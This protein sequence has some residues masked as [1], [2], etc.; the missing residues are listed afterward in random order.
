LKFVVEQTLAG[1]G[2]NLKES[3]IG[4]EVFGRPADYD[5]RIDPIVRVEAR[6]LRSR[7]DKY[8]NSGN[9]SDPVRI[10]LP[11]GSYVPSF[12]STRNRSRVSRAR[13]LGLLAL[14]A[15]LAIAGLLV[16]FAPKTTLVENPGPYALRSPLTNVTA[17]RRTIFL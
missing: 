10:L 5:P 3:V 7:L 14:A 9:S 13:V 12:E 4:V 17:T 1:D 6:R 2:P 11:K 15:V 8:Y 16:A